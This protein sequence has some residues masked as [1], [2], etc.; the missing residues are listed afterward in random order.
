MKFSYNGANYEIEFTRERRKLKIKDLAP[1][2]ITTVTIY[3]TTPG[4]LPGEVVRTGFSTCSYLDNFRKESGRLKALK[5][6]S[7]TLDKPFKRAL[8]DA[9]LNRPRGSA[10]ILKLVPKG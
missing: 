4:K 6:V 3:R 7:R 1:S 10:K 8:W 9:Y 2:R 5:N